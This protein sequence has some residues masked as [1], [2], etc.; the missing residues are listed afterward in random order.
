[1]KSPSQEIEAIH[2]AWQRAANPEE[3]EAAVLRMCES[4]SLEWRHYLD[5]LYLARRYGRVTR[6]PESARLALLERYEDDLFSATADAIAQADGEVRVVPGSRSQ[7][8][9]R[10]G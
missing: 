5:D 8:R 7:A 10:R 4:P 3:M 1:M 6:E 2:R 9:H